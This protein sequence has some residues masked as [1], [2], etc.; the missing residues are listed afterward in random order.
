[1]R[2]MFMILLVA[3]SLTVMAIPSAT[4]DTYNAS[5]SESILE[6]GWWAGDWGDEIIVSGFAAARLPKGAATGELYYSESVGVLTTCDA[7]TPDDP[8]DD[9]IGYIWTGRD[10]WGTAEVTIAKSFATG[11]AVGTVELW[12]SSWSECEWY[13]EGGEVSP[14]NGPG[15]G[16]ET[17]ELT[18][19]LDGDGQL[20]RQSDSY[21]FHIPGQ[22]NEHSRS[23][24]VWRSA[25][26]VVTV[27]DFAHSTS[28]GQIGEYS[29]RSHGNSK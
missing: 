27:D 5:G 19:T 22:Y 4:A 10:G 7:G 24:S 23:R 29:W 11:T 15:P 13:E 18:I 17:A 28:Y 20:M 12:T 14:N 8:D 1:M 16:T 9:Y 2:R 25:V 3:A 26:G 21:R 6:G